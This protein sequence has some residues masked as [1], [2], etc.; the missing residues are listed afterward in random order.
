VEKEFGM[1]LR[2]IHRRGRFTVAALAVSTAFGVATAPSAS[3]ATTVTTVLSG[4]NN[5][6]GV[7]FDGAGHLYLSESG[8]YSN[9][10][11][12]LTRTGRVSK[13]RVDGGTWR[14]V[15][16]NGG[17]ESLSDAENGP[18]VL[19]PEGISAGDGDVKMIMSESID[20]VRAG[21]HL[22]VRAQRLWA[23]GY[24]N[25]QGVARASS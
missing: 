3:A 20:G 11:P 25:R 18:E 22:A 14:K 7:A 12:V 10:A 21:A 8:V 5:P 16:T 23:D 15:W 9:S 24:R 4:L 13:Y 1:A 6:R 2:A 19:G 17:F